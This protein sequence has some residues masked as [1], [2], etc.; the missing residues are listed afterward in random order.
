VFP[1]AAT[2]MTTSSLQISLSST[3]FSAECVSSSA[4]SMAFN[5]ALMPPAIIK[6]RRSFGQLNVGNNSTPSCTA[7]L[8]EVPAP[9]Y[10]NLPLEFKFKCL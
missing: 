9:A 3:I 5:K 6:S 7:I 10:I 8:A 4:F 2:P 1:L